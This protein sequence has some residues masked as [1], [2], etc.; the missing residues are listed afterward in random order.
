MRSIIASFILLALI[1]PGMALSPVEQAYLDGV[2]SGLNLGQL[3]NDVERYN[4]AVQQFNDHLNQTFGANASMMWLPKK[5]VPFT[6]ATGK[7]VHKIDGTPNEISLIQ[8]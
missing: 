7:P 2:K 4:L 3:I 6:V 8:Y 5:A 1:M